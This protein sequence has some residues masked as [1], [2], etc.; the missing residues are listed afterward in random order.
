MTLSNISNNSLTAKLLKVVGVTT[1][2]IK[3]LSIKTLSIKTLSIKTLSIKTL[4]IKVYF[5]TRSL[6]DTQHNNILPIC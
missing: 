4:S 2:R 5:E 3:I 6:N 1:L